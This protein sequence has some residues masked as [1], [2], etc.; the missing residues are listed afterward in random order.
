MALADSRLERTRCVAESNVYHA[1]QQRFWIEMPAS[2]QRIY[3]R[4]ERHWTP[5]GPRTDRRSEHRWP[6]QGNGS[7]CALCRSETAEAA[8]AAADT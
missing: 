1:T 7:A 5:F 4:C 6:R 2:N 3:C 8:R